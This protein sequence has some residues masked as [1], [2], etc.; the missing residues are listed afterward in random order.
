MRGAGIQR[1][2][3]QWKLAHTDPSVAF[4]ASPQ[5]AVAF[6]VCRIIETFSQLQSL[7]LTP[8]IPR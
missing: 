7:T 5:T 6:L 3:D 2:R 4:A 8:G 1:K